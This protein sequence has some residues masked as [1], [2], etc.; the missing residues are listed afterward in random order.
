MTAM[1]MTFYFW[2]RSLRNKNSWWIGIIAGLAYVYMVAAWGGF[3][4]VLNMVALHAGGLVLCNRYSSKLHRAYSLFYIVGTLG[5]IQIPVQGWKPLK[6]MEQLGALVVFLGMQ[7]L[8]V[9]EW[10]IKREERRTKEKF[11][12]YEV[13]VL[14]MKVF[15]AVGAAG[16]VLLSIFMP[17]GYF[18]PLS[19]RVR[20]LF[21]QH[22]RTGNP[23]VDSVAEHQPATADAY[24]RFLH[25]I[26]YYGPVGFVISCFKKQTRIIFG[27]LRNYRIL[28]LHKNESAYYIAWTNRLLTRR[29]SG[30]WYGQLVY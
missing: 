10:I 1:M 13:Q 30:F 3:I 4:F 25:F 18:G 9:C 7:L 21:V 16:I 15:A 27:V 29:Y 2:V 26:C 8:E 5:A 28:F 20:G 14:R 11:N 19:S 24:F 22:T 23:L 17:A 12:F 6:D